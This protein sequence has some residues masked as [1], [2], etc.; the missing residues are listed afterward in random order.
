MQNLPHAGR[1]VIVFNSTL[2]VNTETRAETLVSRILGA[3]NP[4]MAGF[5]CATT[6]LSGAPGLLLLLGHLGVMRGVGLMRR[7]LGVTLVQG[8][9]HVGEH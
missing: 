2:M 6:N 1:S 3:K 7:A 5:W 9:A 8:H 4:A